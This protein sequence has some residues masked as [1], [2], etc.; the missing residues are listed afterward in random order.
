M[1][2][3]VDIPENVHVPPRDYA[4]ALGNDESRTRIVRHLTT[5]L[6][7]L[8]GFLS[9]FAADST[10]SLVPRLGPFLPYGVAAAK[11]CVLVLMLVGLLRWRNRSLE[12]RVLLMASVGLL[13]PML[14]YF[15]T[16]RWAVLPWSLAAL[17]AAAAFMRKIRH[18]SM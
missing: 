4:L 11:L 3:A 8:S 1:T 6:F 15:N 14:V 17:V 13:A 10:R 7:D 18:K 5:G 16:D 12:I 9:R 2:A